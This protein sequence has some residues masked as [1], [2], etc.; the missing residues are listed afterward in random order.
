M[1]NEGLH[2]CLSTR[3]ESKTLN[4]T[5]CY[6]FNK[7]ICSFEL[8]TL[9]HAVKFITSLASFLLIHT[10]MVTISRKAKS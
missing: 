7:I 1:T 10:D 3:Y 5:S 8:M 4:P 9:F 6:I 2:P